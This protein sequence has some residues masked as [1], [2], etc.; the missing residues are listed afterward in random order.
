MHAMLMNTHLFRHNKVGM[1]QRIK[2]ELSRLWNHRM[3]KKFI[4]TKI[5][6]QTKAVDLMHMSSS[7]P[8]F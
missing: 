1:L 6:R 2:L 8:G 4:C 7:A 3:V 5:T